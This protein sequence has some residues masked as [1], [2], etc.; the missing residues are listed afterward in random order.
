MTTHLHG[1]AGQTLLEA[2]RDSNH[3]LHAPCAGRGSCGRCR[4]ILPDASAAASALAACSPE[5]DE[6]LA[7]G[8]ALRGVRLA[9]LA[10]FAQ[11][12]AVEVELGDEGI[13]IPAEKLSVRFDDAVRQAAI[14]SGRPLRVAIDVGTTTLAVALVDA[15]SDAVLTVRSEANCQ[16]SWGSDVVARIESVV[17]D[18]RALTA[19]QRA[20]VRQLDRLI[21]EALLAHRRKRDEVGLV[22]VAGNTTM[23]HLLS[24]ADPTGMARLPFR[25]AFLEARRLPARDCGFR[26]AADCELLLLPGISA[27]VGADIT[28]GVLATG[29]H[30]AEAIELLLDIGTN[31]EIVLGNAT[32]LFATATA[33]G[34]AFEGAQIADGCPGIA[35]ALDHCGEGGE[36]FWYTTIADAPLV[37]ICGSGLLD[38][39]AWLRRSGGIDETGYLALADGGEVFRPDAAFPIGLSQRDIRQLQLAKGAIAAGIA[40]LCERA[41]IAVGEI[42]RVHLAGGFGSLLRA[43]SALDIGLLPPE[44]RGRISAAG[45]TSLK[46]CLLAITRSSASEDCERIAVSVEAVDLAGDPGFQMTFA[47]CMLFPDSLAAHGVHDVRD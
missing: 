38:L 18:A 34:P 28:A 32:R 36:G 29:M 13:A 45:N 20:L 43:A 5:E 4:V 25:P 27:F 42:A 24:G 19:M 2:I 39:V 15:A 35:G 40:I 6:L 17:A 1:L 3:K 10:R 8:E 16:R 30:R 14:A 23:L 46:G 21:Q 11:A 22:A 44:L 37:G 12:G 9:C 41:G 33:A 7:A 31:G 47:D 26:L